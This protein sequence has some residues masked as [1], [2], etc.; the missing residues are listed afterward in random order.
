MLGQLL[1]LAVSIGTESTL[2][3]ARQATMQSHWRLS[4]RVRVWM[5]CWMLRRRLGCGLVLK[6]TLKT[7]VVPSRSYILTCLGSI[8]QGLTCYSI[9]YHALAVSDEATDMSGAYFMGMLMRF[10]VL[11][12]AEE[13]VLYRLSDLH[14]NF[15]EFSFQKHAKIIFIHN[16][17]RILSICADN[18]SGSVC[19]C[20][21][22]RWLRQQLRP[23]RRLGSCQWSDS[24]SWCH[25]PDPGPV[26]N[27]QIS[28]RIIPHRTRTHVCARTHKNAHLQHPQSHTHARTKARTHAQTHE[29]SRTRARTRRSGLWLCLSTTARP[30]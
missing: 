13:Q 10:P 23:L 25:L 24:E 16:G 14:T 1:S 15:A 6:T 21:V 29:P 11:Q 4:V 27:T 17:L 28:P 3:A 12:A 26:S 8:R 22:R 18:S 19:S 5:F 9:S 30:L 2:L 7:S 20:C